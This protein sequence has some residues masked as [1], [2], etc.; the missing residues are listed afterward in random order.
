MSWV[1]SFSAVSATFDSRAKADKVNA[2]LD[3]YDRADGP[4]CAVA[5]IHDGGIV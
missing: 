3:R 5:V 1:L 2:V 4:G